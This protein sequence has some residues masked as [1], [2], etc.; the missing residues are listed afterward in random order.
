MYSY[1]RRASSRFKHWTR[2]QRSREL[3]SIQ[4]YLMD[5]DAYGTKLPSKIQR[6]A[7]LPRKLTEAEEDV[8]M[9]WGYSNVPQDYR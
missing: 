3:A 8:L 1:D 5:L 9:E 4:D 2:K 6:I 7:D